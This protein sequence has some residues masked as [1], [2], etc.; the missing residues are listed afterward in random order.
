MAE[1]RHGTDLT[2]YDCM[3][4]DGDTV[5]FDIWWE[6]ESGWGGEHLAEYNLAKEA[7]MAGI[8]HIIDDML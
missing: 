7:W 5:M 6:E 4:C 8:Q 3:N 2:E 1:C